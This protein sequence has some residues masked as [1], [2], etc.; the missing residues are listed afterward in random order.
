[1]RLPYNKA[2][3]PRARYLRQHMTKEELHLWLDFLRNH[4]AKFRR[5]EII[6]NY[7][8]DFFSY[9]VMIAIE[10][11]GSQHYEPETLR[12]DQQRDRYL[13]EQGITVLRYTNL[14]IQR[15][16]DAVCGH[17]AHHITHGGDLIC[18][19]C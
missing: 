16:F 18:A 19:L 3:V 13:R 6:G 2:L 8:I 14:D 11:D 4:P 7:I 5:Q 10:L 1:M 12:Y 17:I 15:E 9:E